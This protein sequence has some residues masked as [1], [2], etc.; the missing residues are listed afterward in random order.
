MMFTILYRAG[1]HM[2]SI[3]FTRHA[4]FFYRADPCKTTTF[5]PLPNSL[6]KGTSIYTFF[7]ELQPHFYLIFPNKTTSVAT[8]ATNMF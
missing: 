2:S 7:S 1:Q 6:P 5:P 8:D 4:S 3:V